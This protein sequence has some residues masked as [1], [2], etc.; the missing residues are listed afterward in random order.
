MDAKAATVQLSVY[1]KLK[2]DVGRTWGFTPEPT[3]IDF[4]KWVEILELGTFNPVEQIAIKAALY[5]HRRAATKK[6]IF[7][8]LVAGEYEDPEVDSRKIFREV[9]A[10]MKDDGSSDLGLFFLNSFL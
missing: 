4:G 10:V 3:V 8:T 9:E 7:S 2:D 5:N 6:I 1:L